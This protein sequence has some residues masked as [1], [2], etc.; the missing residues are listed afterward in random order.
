MLFICFVQEN[1]IESN[2]QIYTKKVGDLIVKSLSSL[3]SFSVHNQVV[4]DIGKKNTTAATVKINLEKMIVR[5][6]NT[7]WL[8]FKSR[9]SKFYSNIQ[10]KLKSFNSLQKPHF[11]R[12]VKPNLRQISGYFHDNFVLDQLESSGVAAYYKLMQFGYPDKIPMNV[13]YDKLKP[14]LQPRHT[15]LDSRIC[16]LIF[17]I[18]SGFKAGDLKIGQSSINIRAGNSQLLEKVLIEING[19]SSELTLKFNSEYVIFMRRTIF[20]KFRFIGKRKI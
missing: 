3:S 18:A 8:S 6:K 19:I 5:L 10:L 2:T 14:I 20:I 9:I 17:M 15:S 12:C 1:F 11:I 4:L 13:L 7:V 16:C